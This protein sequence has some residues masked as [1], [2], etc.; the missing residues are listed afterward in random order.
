MPEASPPP[1]RDPAR[2]DVT[3]VSC[4]R[5][6]GLFIVEW[7]AYHSLM[8]FA[9]IL[10]FTN[11]CTDGSDLLLDRLQA[12]GHLTHVRH[13]PPPGQSP[14][15]TAMKLAFQHPRVLAHEWLL[16]IDSDEF[17][18]VDAGDGTI[19]ALIDATQP[20][21][22]VAIGWKCF[23][24][25]GK[26]RWD[27]GNVLQEF[28]RS[29]GRPMRRIGFHKSLYRHRLFDYGTDHMPKMPKR[30]DVRVV[31]T[32]GTAFQPATIHHRRKSRYKLDFRLMTFQNAA[33]YHYVIKSDDLYVMK[34]DRGD[35]HGMTHTKYYLNSEAHARHN[36]N[37]ADD[38]TILDR[39]PAIAARIDA[40]RS[41]PE[42]ARLEAACIAA[43]RARR[44]LVLTP[45]QL[46]A[47]SF[48]PRT[49]ATPET[50]N[51]AEDD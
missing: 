8:G 37:D 5:N 15:I 43:F 21:D 50:D 46:A 4:M 3:L 45:E 36:R 23:G 2:R 16:H 51:E 31:T 41:D 26:T 33:I 35:G 6:E 10:V 9:D 42:I 48:P 39:W 22:V 17:L 19:G 25:A 1:D 38:R 30:D 12:L 29:Q 44:D 18:R 34:N 49:A 20:A 47:W 27:G 11:N 40:L 24:N 7:V 13:D 32:A 14:Q 28:T